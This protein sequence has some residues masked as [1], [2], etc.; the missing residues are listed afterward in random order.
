[1]SIGDVINPQGFK[2]VYENE[3]FD[4][5]AILEKYFPTEPSYFVQ[6][7]NDIESIKILVIDGRGILKMIY[8]DVSM[9]TFCKKGA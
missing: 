1:M 8:D 5:V 9:F 3:Y 6:G 2:V 7:I 4:V